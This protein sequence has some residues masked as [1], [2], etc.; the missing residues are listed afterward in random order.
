MIPTM[1]IS[2]MLFFAIIIA[3]CIQAMSLILK[4]FQN[5]FSTDDNALA[6]F[7]VPFVCM[8]MI[9][10]LV[11]S[12]IKI[13]GKL[14]DSLVG[15]KS[16]PAFQKDAKAIIVGAMKAGLTLGVKVAGFALPKPVANW[17]DKKAKK[18]VGKEGGEE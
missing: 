6:E 11:M 15:G 12:S 18:L 3:V 8:M 14:C 4:S 7:S 13:A 9:A 2:P 10:F 16:N 1:T 5:V 17:L